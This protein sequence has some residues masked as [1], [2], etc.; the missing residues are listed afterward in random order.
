M[1]C[2]CPSDSIEVGDDYCIKCGD[3]VPNEEQSEC[4]GMITLDVSNISMFLWDLVKIFFK[5]LST[6]TLHSN[7]EVK[8]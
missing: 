6:L 1:H 4:V 8:Y 5:I 7:K 3:D 2:T